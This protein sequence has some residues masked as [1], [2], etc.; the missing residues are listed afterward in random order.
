L[1]G[2]RLLELDRVANIERITA[3]MERQQALAESLNQIRKEGNQAIAD[4]EAEGAQ[5]AMTPLQRQI[6]V[7]SRANQ[8][9]AQQAAESFAKQFEGM[10]MTV[11]QGQEL[12]DGLDLITQKY[13]KLTEV[14]VKNLNSSRSFATGWKKAFDEYVDA[15]TNAA[16]KAER[17]FMKFTSGIEDALVD[18]VK[19]GK[20]NWKSF[21]A[22]MAEELLRNQIKETIAGFGQALGLSS[23]FG[24]SSSGAAI[25][26]SPSKPMY[27]VDISGGATGA[28]GT[29]GSILDSILGGNKSGS[30]GGFFDGILNVGKSIFGG[31][32]D[33]FG[34][35]FANGGNIPAG[36]FGIV[37]ER[38]PEF[39]GGPASVMPMGG[40]GGQVTYI[41]NAVDAPSFQALVA[42]DPGFIY[43]VTEQGRRN[44]P[45]TRR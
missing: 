6:D 14:Q 16:A 29:G 13:Y 15:A 41:I 39:V 8:R 26:S 32:S 12:A 34:G 45:M 19:T 23:I 35:F 31:I 11:K 7:I 20:L 27:V 2:Q 25:G 44:L 42:R 22:D 43:A 38:G 36:K 5:A 40:G 10:D 30:S 28:S 37:G 33:L 4:A 9:A 3:A 18:F 1:Q 24:G 21:V 17:L